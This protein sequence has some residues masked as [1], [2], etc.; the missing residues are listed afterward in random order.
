MPMRP[1]PDTRLAVIAAARRR[2]IPAAAGVAVVCA[3]MLM[4]QVRAQTLAA[5]SQGGTGRA[6]T[7]T[8]SVSTSVVLTDNVNL[9]ARDKQSDV[10]L[11]ISP[12]IR[13]QSNGGRVRGALDYSPSAYVYSKASDKN[14]VA[15]SLNAALTTEAVEDWA[16]VDLSAT[17]SQQ[18]ISA[19]GTQVA[20][21]ALGGGNQTQ[22]FSY[23]VSPYIKGKLFGSADYEFRL[24]AGESRTESSTVSDSKSEQALLRVNGATGLSSLGWGTSL[25]HQV[26]DFSAGR[27]TTA[28]RFR[29][30]L[31][32]ALSPQLNVS[33]F[34][35]Y[36]SSDQV[37]ATRLDGETYGF[38]F[39]W[40]PSE[41]T[42]F[43]GERERRLFGNTY[44]LSFE[45][46]MPRSV[47]RYGASRDVSSGL[48]NATGTVVSAYDLYFAQF[49]SIEP[50]PVRR[51]VL[52]NN[53]LVVNGI[54]PTSTV[55]GGSVSSGLTL[56]RR[57]EL[58]VGLLGVRSTVTLLLTRGNSKRLDGTTPSSGNFVGTAG[59]DQRAFSVNVG[60]R[61][62]SISSLSLLLSEQRSAGNNSL[63]S[64]KLQLVSL[65]WSS[66][67]GPRSSVS[68]GARHSVF[69]SPTAPY[70]ESA[71][72]ALFSLQF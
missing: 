16:F 23:S 7:L 34:G 52:V 36:E 60:H 31:T 1:V 25:Q 35:G 62:T 20:D 67:L 40:R 2:T 6:F 70:N 15:H 41:R 17:A 54:S 44:S 11:Q 68:F 61:L 9:S 10:Y 32:Y 56:Q 39:N 3:L 5:P 8:P 19:L 30:T 71:V 38:G 29:G 12:A 49:A 13:L 69:D 26:D 59:V 14:R 4:G 72:T 64:N 53:F 22:V 66:K 28:D 51:Q 33:A 24:R 18:S 50:D 65:T 58:A 45:H 55:G 37:G 43:S 57:Q 46:R 48:N 63:S 21:P 42:K 27:R 47:F